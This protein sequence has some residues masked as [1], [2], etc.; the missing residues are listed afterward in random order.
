MV[1]S[2]AKS[3]PLRPKI[4]S[5][6]TAWSI[7][8]DTRRQE[9]IRDT[10]LKKN[11]TKSS[12]FYSQD[13]EDKPCAS[14]ST[15]RHPAC[16]SRH[17][18]DAAV[19]DENRKKKKKG[20]VLRVEQRYRRDSLLMTTNICL[21]FVSTLVHLWPLKSGASR[22][23]TQ[24]AGNST[25]MPEGNTHTHAADT[26]L[27]SASAPSWQNKIRIRP[28]QIRDLILICPDFNHNWKPATRGHTQRFNILI[29]FP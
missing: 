14:S 20:N 26:L 19:L 3:C 6:L 5:H 4:F 8:R 11:T 9:T 7:C 13:H 28:A 2:V 12:H 24:S 1:E 29:K 27:L 22:G 25:I 18:T 10:I 23:H 21:C 15:V 17:R 16:V